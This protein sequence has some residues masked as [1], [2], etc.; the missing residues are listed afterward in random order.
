M[1]LEASEPPH[2]FI[3]M[4]KAGFNLMKCRRHGQ[5]VTGYR[6]TVDAPGQL[7]GNITMGDAISENGV[8]THIPVIGSIQYRASCHLFRRSLQGSHL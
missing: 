7:G 5:N 6:A 4:D 1:E 8:Q 2:N 3:Y